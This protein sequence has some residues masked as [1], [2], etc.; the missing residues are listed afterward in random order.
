MM[1]FF[2]KIVNGL[3][4]Y[5]FNLLQNGISGKLIMFLTGFLHD[6]KQSYIKQPGVV[7]GRYQNKSSLRIYIKTVLSLNLY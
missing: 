7:V 5:F 2:V 3:Q 4:H 1:E 6:R